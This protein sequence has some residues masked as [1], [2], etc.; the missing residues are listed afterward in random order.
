[1][2]RLDPRTLGVYVVTSGAAVAGRDHR[3]IVSAAVEGGATAVQ[4]RAPE[5]ADDELLPLATSSTQRCAE[6]G[7]PLLVNDRVEVAVGVGA[8]GAHVGQGDDP[9]T[10]RGRLGPER[11]LGV[12]V[13]SAED[14]WVAEMAGADYLGVTVWATGSKP[15]AVPLGVEGLRDIAAATTLPV[16]GIGGIHLGN[17]REVL[18]AGAAGIAVIGAVAGATDPVEAVRELRALVETFQ[19]E[20][21]R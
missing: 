2:A 1:M 3:T 15:E 6:A 10:A 9:A 7:I 8:A 16:V 5:L 13:R 14:V 4:L 20:R 17:A 19:G 11:I 12:S 21:P 18:A